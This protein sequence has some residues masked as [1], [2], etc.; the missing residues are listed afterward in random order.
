MHVNFLDQLQRKLRDAQY[1][2]DR[3]VKIRPMD[4]NY[5][6][7]FAELTRE[8]KVDL[9]SLQTDTSLKVLIDELAVLD[10]N[11]T[12]VLK[13]FRKILGFFTLG[14]SSRR[15]VVKSQKVYIDSTIRELKRQYAYLEKHLSEV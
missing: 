3:L 10:P 14:W 7:Q 5:L 11:Y 8:I 9:Q 13:T 4:Q 15:Y 1:Q 2:S 6:M 12:P